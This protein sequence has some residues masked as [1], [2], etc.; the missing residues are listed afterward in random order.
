L[1]Y[2]EFVASPG[3]QKTLYAQSGGQP[4]HRGAWLD[5]DLNAATSNFFAATLPTLDSAWVRPRFPGFI[6]FQDAASTI[7][8]RYLL[9][10]GDEPKTLERMNQALV[11]ARK[12]VA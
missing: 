10:G 8:H 9:D 3:V 6:G 5:R 11:Q 7:V 12:Q 2:A 1:A 4:G